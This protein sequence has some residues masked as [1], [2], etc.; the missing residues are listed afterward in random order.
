VA[1]IF[2]D[3]SF[4]ESILQH[5]VGFGDYMKLAWITASLA[6][7]AGALGSGLEDEETVRDATYGYRQ[8]RRNEPESSSDTS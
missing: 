2:V 4:L 8:R 7:V 3:R 6:T 5:P 1:G